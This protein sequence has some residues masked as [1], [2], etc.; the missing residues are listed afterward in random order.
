MNEPAFTEKPVALILGASGGIGGAVAEALSRRGYRIRAMHRS[1]E[2]QTG[3]QPDYEWVAGDAM[4]RADV[5]SAAH[6]A[7]LIFHGVNPPGYKN[8]QALVVPMI[9]NTIAAARLSGARILFPGTVYNFGPDALPEP[10]EDSPQNATTRKGRIRAALEDRLR[11]AAWEGTPVILVRA[12]DFFGGRAGFSNSWFSQ[13]V[14]AGKPLRTVTRL[15]KPGIGHQWAYLPDLAETFAELNAKAE[16]LPSYA[17]Y[18]FEGFWDDDGLQMVAAIRRAVGK[19]ALP[20]RP[21]PWFVVPLLSP[22]VPLMREILEIRYLW[23]TPLHMHNDRLV[24]ALGGAEPR[25]PVDEAVILTLAAMGVLEK[26]GEPETV[27]LPAK[28]QVSKA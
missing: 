25:T 7:A 26:S 8:W 14:K 27:S 10:D 9:E 19:P 4:N 18:H 21:F 23:R 12:G 24:A 5:V 11:E 6:G 15:S 28:A 17:A 3:R 2:A 20:V 22:F 1:P 13:M 16:T